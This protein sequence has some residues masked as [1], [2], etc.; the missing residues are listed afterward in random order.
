[1]WWQAQGPGMLKAL[2]FGYH[3]FLG[4]TALG[5]VCIAVSRW[6][7][8]VQ[9]LKHVEGRRQVLYHCF[10]KLPLYLERT[11]KVRSSPVSKSRCGPCRGWV[12]LTVWLLS[13]H[14]WIGSRP[15]LYHQSGSQLLLNGT[16]C[17]HSSRLK[18]PGPIF[19]S[20][21]PRSPNAET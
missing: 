5:D 12:Q 10:Y 14:S 9:L 20:S 15:S 6:Y 19:G 18:L 16:H 8:M 13:K 1:M 21:G 17:S 4:L 7:C 3:C 11:P 2:G